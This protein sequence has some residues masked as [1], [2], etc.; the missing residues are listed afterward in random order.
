MSRRG[1]RVVMTALACPTWV[2]TMDTRSVA[3]QSMATV[4]GRVEIGVSIKTR[5]ASAAYA[6]RTAVAPTSAHRA[7]AGEPTLASGSELRNVVIYL[8]DAP[9][10]SAPPIRAEIRQRGENF[11]P[12][13]VAVP[14]GSVVDFP[15]DD[16]I[17]HN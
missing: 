15:N 17:Y 10:R 7:M 4:R 12:R 2:A 9:P 11:F 13:V 14:V 5:R 8:K 6:G 16:D 3:Q 1:A